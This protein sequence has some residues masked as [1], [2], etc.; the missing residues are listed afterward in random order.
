MDF[1]CFAKFNNL[2]NGKTVVKPQCQ[3]ADVKFFNIIWIY[4]KYNFKIVGGGGGYNFGKFVKKIFAVRVR[5]G[6]LR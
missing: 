5:F 2:L 4:I 6:N 1:T 3:A